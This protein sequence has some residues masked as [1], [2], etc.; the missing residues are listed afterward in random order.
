MHKEVIPEFLSHLPKEEKKRLML[1][2]QSWKKWEIA[3]IIV[4]HYED[5]LDRL[6]LE[7]EKESLLSMFQSKWARAKRMGKRKALRLVIKHL[8]E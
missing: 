6:V 8:K 4:K 7:E 1:Q 2:Y 3:E 5:K